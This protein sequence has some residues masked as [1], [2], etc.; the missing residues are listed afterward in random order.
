MIP[1]EVRGW[2]PTSHGCLSYCI[3]TFFHHYIPRKSIKSNWNPIQSLF[4]SW[5]VGNQKII[6]CLDIS[7]I[8]PKLLANQLSQQRTAAPL[9]NLWVMGWIDHQYSITRSFEGWFIPITFIT[10]PSHYIFP[11]LHTVFMVQSQLLDGSIN[12]H[13]TVIPNIPGFFMDNSTFFTVNIFKHHVQSSIFGWFS[14]HQAPRSARRAR[15][16][17]RSWSWRSRANTCGLIDDLW[18]DWVSMLG[19]MAFY[20]YI[21]SLRDNEK[22]EWD[23]INRLEI[24]VDYIYK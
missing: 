5:P 12:K 8:N 24:S 17:S 3:I 16:F 10:S 11:I 14:Q 7:S 21:W 23:K 13:H 1:I 20:S 15:A 4:V 22:D 2:T 18:R 9:C 6:C 19:N